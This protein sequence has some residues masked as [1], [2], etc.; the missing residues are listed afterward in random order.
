LT[1]ENDDKEGLW[2][3]HEL[4]SEVSDHVDVPV[5]FD[6]HHHSFTDRGLTYREAF[7]LAADTWGKVTPATH[8]SEP[9]RLHGADAKPQAH[10]EYVSDVPAKLTAASDVMLEANEKERAL[11]H[12]HDQSS[13]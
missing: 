4:V 6:Y 10:S 13:D 12:Y 8:Y 3:V 2:S 7:E 11:L 1:I 5:V 9:A